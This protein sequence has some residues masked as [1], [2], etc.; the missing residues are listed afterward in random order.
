MNIYLHINRNGLTPIS[1]ET[2]VVPKPGEVIEVN[3]H[4]E[5]V[6]EYVVTAVEPKYT[7]VQPNNVG[8]LKL[9]AEFNVWLLKK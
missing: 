1:C 2:E 5:E 7:V 3:Y 6:G 4:R 9:E 8:P